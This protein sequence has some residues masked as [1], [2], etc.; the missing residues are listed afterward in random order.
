MGGFF[1]DQEEY[2]EVPR[3]AG[4]FRFALSCSITTT[5]KFSTR[6][7]SYATTF[8]ILDREPVF[9][10]DRSISPSQRYRDL[11]DL[12]NMGQLFH[13]SLRVRS[14]VRSSGRAFTLG[15]LEE[16]FADSGDPGDRSTSVTCGRSCSTMGLSNAP[17]SAS[18]PC[19]SSVA[20]TLTVWR[21]FTSV[22]NGHA[23]IRARNFLSRSNTAGSYSQP[24]YWFCRTL[25]GV[26]LT[27]FD[28]ACEVRCGLA[29]HK[30]DRDRSHLHNAGLT[31]NYTNKQP[32]P[33]QKT[34][35]LSPS[36]LFQLIAAVISV[37]IRSRSTI[38][39]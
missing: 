34:T 22:F 12:R 36:P 7:Q 11:N 35:D 24:S 19:S 30:L 20:T 29:F 21:R 2:H 4:R 31:C 15:S 13:G 18:S 27:C 33:S 38:L 25:L 8:E 5:T 14:L 10:R 17:L 26:I 16:V 28:I 6:P 32:Y 23:A 39:L 37:L 1:Q 3:Q 9:G